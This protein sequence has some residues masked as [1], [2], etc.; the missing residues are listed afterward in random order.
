MFY[1]CSNLSTF[2]VP[3]K[4]IDSL[5]RLRVPSTHKLHGEHGLERGPVALQPPQP[6]ADLVHT[7]PA[8]ADANQFRWGCTTRPLS[9]INPT[10]PPTT[11]LLSPAVNHE[12]CGR[13]GAEPHVVAN[14]RQGGRRRGRFLS[15]RRR[16]LSSA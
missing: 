9:T 1:G 16:L 7:A 12:Q 13:V 6:P 15:P 3:N 5:Q 4:I 2:T 8:P 11:A 10:A 14:H